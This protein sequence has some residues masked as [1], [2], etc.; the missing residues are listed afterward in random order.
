VPSILGVLVERVDVVRFADVTTVKL[1]GRR[2]RFARFLCNTGGW[3]TIGVSEAG[4]A[5]LERN[6]G[7]VALKPRW[8]PGRS[9]KQRSES[10]AVVRPK[11]MLAMAGRSCGG[12]PK[13]LLSEGTAL[14]WLDQAA[15]GEDVGTVD[16][17]V[18]EMITYGIIDIVRSAE[19]AGWNSLDRERDAIKIG[20]PRLPALRR[21]KRSR[22]S[23][24][25]PLSNRDA[26]RSAPRVAA[27]ILRR[28]H[29]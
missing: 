24:C 2:S 14:P 29:G 4:V 8:R 26:G 19:N 22:A 9:Q 6:W 13:K 25:G 3:V 21:D 5:A 12:R 1:P 10:A 27:E 11:K 18:I 7:L 23:G 28:S 16:A 20:S 17:D 15:I